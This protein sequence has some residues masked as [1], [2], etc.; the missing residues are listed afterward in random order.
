MQAYIICYIP[1]M[2]IVNFTG[3]CSRI[4]CVS[5]NT[6]LHQFICKFINGIRDYTLSIYSPFSACLPPLEWLDSRCGI[7]RWS[8][9]DCHSALEVDGRQK[10]CQIQAQSLT[11]YYTNINYINNSIHSPVRSHSLLLLYIIRKPKKRCLMI[12]MAKQSSTRWH[13]RR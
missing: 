5:Q 12:F 4:S 10:K 8:A 7:L 6:P 1:Y 2:Y 13:D 3:C 9:L 11:Q